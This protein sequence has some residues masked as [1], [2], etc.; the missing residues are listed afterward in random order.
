MECMIYLHQDQR[1]RHWCHKWSSG[2]NSRWHQDLWLVGGRDACS[3]NLKTQVQ[4]LEPT[5]PGAWLLTTTR[6]PWYFQIYN[7][8]M[9]M[10][11]TRHVRHTYMHTPHIITKR[12]AIHNILE[13]LSFLSSP[14]W[15]FK[16]LIVLY[17]DQS[18]Y[19]AE[20]M[21]T[22]SDASEQSLGPVRLSIPGYSA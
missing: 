16:P 12:K 1:T 10:Y 15:Y 14:D 20:S 9:Y 3:A 4:C 2:L 7:T 19:W 11:T 17:E 13:V 22:E 8:Y 5:G 6:V 21:S 18:A